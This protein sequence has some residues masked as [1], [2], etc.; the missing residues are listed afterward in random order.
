VKACFAVHL[1]SIAIL[2]IVA[3]GLASGIISLV[4]KTIANIIGIWGIIIG[5]ILGL[6]F[7]FFALVSISHEVIL[8][9][10]PFFRLHL[11]FFLD[12]LSS[13]FLVLIFTLSLLCAIYGDEY[14]Q[15]HGNHYK[16]WFLYNLL[17][18]SMVLVAIS[19][20]AISFLVFWELMALT[21]FFLV[22]QDW[23][24]AKSGRASWIYLSFTQIGTA[25]LLMFFLLLWKKAGTADFENFKALQLGGSAGFLF[26]LALIG[27]GSK[28]GIIPFH[29]WLPEA[30]P[31]A[32][33]HVS[34]LMSGIMIKIGIYGLLRALTFLG[35]PDI[36]WGASLIVIGAV[37]GVLGVL[38][39][40]AQHDIKRLLAYHSVENIGIIVIG[41]GIGVLGM[42]IS[43]PLLATL[44]FAGGLLH[45]LNH[46]L[47]KSL[48][49]L[50]AGSVISK[51]NTREINTMGGL[52][53]VL[54]ITA[55][56][57]LIGSLAI[58]GIPP[59]NGFVSEFLIYG[60]SFGGLAAQSMLTVLLLAG[61]ILSLAF[62]GG[63]ALLCFTKAFGIIFL[64]EPRLV[65]I[66]G[67]K[68]NRIKMTAPMM[69]LSFLCVAIGIIPV[70][71]LPILKGPL[72][73][74]C[75]L[76]NTNLCEYSR[77]NSLCAHLTVATL[78]FSVIF[79]LVLLV[80]RLLATGK[81][82]RTG[83]TWDCGF[84]KSSG[85]L[86]YTASSFAFPI[87]D[88]FS[89]IL[90]TKKH[91]DPILDYF[92]ARTSLSAHTQDI[93]ERNFYAP[94]YHLTKRTSNTLFN[95]LNR[96]DF[97]LKN[98]YDRIKTFWGSLWFTILRRT[99]ARLLLLLKSMRWR[100][101]GIRAIQHGDM[102]IY[103]LYI[104]AALC[105]LLIFFIGNYE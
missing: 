26:I 54:P 47:F 66:A 23:D 81:T 68:E 89:G 92:P 25:A 67:L 80:R 73:T 101:S 88:F 105:I 2:I 55:L 100:L 10:I 28:A 24:N 14:L 61:A 19:G 6:V 84:I 69:A 59:F 56:A 104:I 94:L 17:A 43:S 102:R 75:C 39:A 64:G 32:P 95:V 52:I 29:I 97:L 51:T 49:F 85:R 16:M 42:A 3:A 57:F 34:A 63:L 96:K 12:P 98:V 58:A 90:R 1:L 65:A 50:S 36:L 37:S 99:K 4:S 18:A 74:V 91:G 70:L 13:F 21:S 44:G 31:A 71:V 48:L 86:Q 30:H 38:L 60:A 87:V 27:F 103:L 46:A 79:L 53:K 7:S 20:D 78:S 76:H 77:V 83:V 15:A 33:S 72:Q 9:P 11:T 8:L 35:T 40:I 45:V 93:A 41:I 62:I 5:C 22:A 82:V